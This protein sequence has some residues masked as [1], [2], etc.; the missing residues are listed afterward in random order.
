MIN[1]LAGGTVVLRWL[2]KRLP[3]RLKKYLVKNRMFASILYFLRSKSRLKA[4]DKSIIDI[5]IYIQAYSTAYHLLGRFQENENH[6]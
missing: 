5:L 3:L 1:N 2:E 4:F 6:F